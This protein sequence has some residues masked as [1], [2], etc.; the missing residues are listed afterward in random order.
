MS[1]P[2]GRV[3]E[4][5]ADTM[6]VVLHEFGMDPDECTYTPTASRFGQRGEPDCRYTICGLE[7]HIEAKATG[8][9]PTE[10]QQTR[11]NALINSGALVVVVVGES[12]AHDI[13]RFLPEMILTHMAITAQV[14]AK[15]AS[16][17][18]RIKAACTKSYRP[19][20]KR[21]IDKPWE[22]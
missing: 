4:I 17:G 11:I 18:G 15:K 1:T 3:R 16:V 9:V 8:K 5:I 22:D 13:P 20:K 14:L 2:E 7:V 12:H 6:A 21:I 19:A 10:I